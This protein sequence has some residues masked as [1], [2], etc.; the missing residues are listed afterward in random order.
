MND[1]HKK[2]SGLCG[3]GSSFLY[4][5]FMGINPTER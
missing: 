1:R 5:D 4:S 2:S 3:L